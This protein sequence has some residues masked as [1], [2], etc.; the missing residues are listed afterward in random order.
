MSPQLSVDR[1]SVTFADEPQRSE[2]S[3]KIFSFKST[4]VLEENMQLATVS[5]IH[6]NDPGKLTLNSLN[7]VRLLIHLTYIP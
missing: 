4:L 5:P 2:S 3:P 1:L 7:T 6:Q